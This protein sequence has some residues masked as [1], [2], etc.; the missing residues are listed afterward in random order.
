MVIYSVPV[1]PNT[2]AHSLWSH[3]LALSKYYSPLL[4]R[5]INPQTELIT[6]V[7]ASEGIFSAVQAFINPGDEVIL[8]Q[9]FYDSYPASVRLAG[10]IPVT[11]S[12]KPSIKSGKVTSASEWKLDMSELENAV[13]EKTRMIFVNNPHNP[14]GKCHIPFVVSVSMGFNGTEIVYRKGVFGRRVARDCAYCKE[15]QL[16]RVS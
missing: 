5:S 6:T 14:L 3:V 2:F 15:I 13:S 8:M 4:N 1:G 11:V 9:P 12:L 16:A 10:G 7:G